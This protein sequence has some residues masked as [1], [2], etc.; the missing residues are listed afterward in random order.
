M[1]DL[2]Y[3][4]GWHAA[5]KYA[6]NHL[7]TTSDSAWEDAGGHAWE[8]RPNVECVECPHCAFT[9]AAIHTVAPEDYDCP[10]CEGCPD[11]AAAPADNDAE[12]KGESDA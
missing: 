2:A 12:S 6:R 8:I 10:N 11:F 1:F 7:A 9:F 5:G 4:F 3:R